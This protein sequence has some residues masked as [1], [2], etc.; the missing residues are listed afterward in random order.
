MSLS[1]DLH[2]TNAVYGRRSLSPTSTVDMMPFP[3]PVLEGFLMLFDEF[4]DSPVVGPL[5]GWVK[6]KKEAL[7]GKPHDPCARWTRADR[8]P[9]DSPPL[10]ALR[11]L[12]DF[13]SLEKRLNGPMRAYFGKY[14]C[15]LAPRHSHQW[16][17]QMFHLSSTRMVSDYRFSSKPSIKCTKTYITATLSRRSFSSL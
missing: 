13:N 1:S 10:D 5:L 11:C 2:T 12:Q 7:S 9:V 16:P 4:F 3:M 14:T 17:L 6:E 8:H 15:Y